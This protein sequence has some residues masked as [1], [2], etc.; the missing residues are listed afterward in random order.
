MPNPTTDAT[1]PRGKHVGNKRIDI[2][3]PSLMRSRRDGDQA[4]CKP[5][6]RSSAASM[7]GVTASAHTSS[8]VFR[9]AFKVHPRFRKDDE[10]HPPPM[11]PTWLRM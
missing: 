11:L 2:G 10:S 9:L 1:A 4:N 8:A 6:I 3:R 5:C 7:I